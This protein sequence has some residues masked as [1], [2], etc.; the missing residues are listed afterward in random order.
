MSELEHLSKLGLID[1]YYGDESRVSMEP[2]VPYGWQFAGEDVFM[3]SIKGAGLNCFFRNH[4][5]VR[6]WVAYSHG[7]QS[8]E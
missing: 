1:L 5:E 6:V 2:C 4:Y 3:P 7:R 8:S